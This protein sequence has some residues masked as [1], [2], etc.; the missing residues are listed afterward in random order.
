MRIAVI[1][2]AHN[3][4]W[5]IGLTIPALWLAEVQPEDVY[6]VDD[7][8]SDTTSVIAESC[9]V[10]LLTLTTNVGKSAALQKA[11]QHFKL[12]ERYDYVA[13][14]D[15]DTRV[16]PNYF[17]ALI[18]AVEKDPEAV[19]FLGQVQSQRG[20]YISALRTTEYKVGH[21]LNKEGQ[22]RWGVIFV[23][24]GC[25]SLYRADMLALLDFGGGTLAEDMDFTFQCHRMEM[26]VERKVVYVSDAIVYTQDPPTFRDL[27][28]QVKRW[29]R[30]GWQVAFKY[31]VFPFMGKRQPVDLYLFF[32]MGF[33]L[34]INRYTVFLPL[35]LYWLVYQSNTLLFGYFSP[36]Q[37]VLLLVS[38]D[39][40]TLG[41]MGAYAGIK[42]GRPDAFFKLPFYFWIF[43]VM[44]LTHIQTFFE[45][46][47]A[48]KGS[49]MDWTRVPRYT[50]SPETHPQ[51]S[52]VT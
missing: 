29:Q 43:Y 10:Q 23:A 14:L 39:F 32:Q 9:G 8:S 12:C 15:A 34:I 4:E 30:G 37:V 2:P 28:K 40:L 50:S 35:M 46:V 45:V 6:V 44:Q 42:T 20:G 11:I 19:L 5:V 51:G 24:P 36:L 18:A 16:D 22:H 41:T 49:K 21:D 1:I 38:V 26:E 47:F 31:H 52:T 3:E 13:F 27:I 25:A 17:T 33:P 7:A 48:K